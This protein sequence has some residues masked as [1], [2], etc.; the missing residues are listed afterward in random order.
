[1]MLEGFCVPVS[2]LPIIIVF[3]GPVLRNSDSRALLETL[4]ISDDAGLSP[5]GIC[6]L[7]VVGAGPAG[8]AAAVYG[9]SEGMATRLAEDIALGGQVGISSRI[10][11][12]LGFFAGVFG[13]EL[14]ARAALQA[15]KFGV[16]IKQAARA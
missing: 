5:Q 15:Q 6:D 3:G 4:G 12:Y 8:L 7:L 14:A 11:N 2:D 13:E 1:Q 9:A 16:R 10:E